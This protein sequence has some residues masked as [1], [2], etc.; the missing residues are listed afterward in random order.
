MGDIVSYANVYELGQRVKELAGANVLL[1]GRN[2]DFIGHCPKC[3]AYFDIGAQ[4]V[5]GKVTR[6]FFFP[7]QNRE[8]SD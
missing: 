5:A 1:D 4:I 2:D 6:V 3:R 8:K 7:Q